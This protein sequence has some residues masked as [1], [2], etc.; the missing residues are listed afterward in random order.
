MMRA[1]LRF[2]RASRNTLDRGALAAATLGGDRAIDRPAGKGTADAARDRTERAM[3]E[4]RIAD[5]RTADATRHQAR[6]PARIA[7]A[8]RIAIAA[9]MRIAV[10]MPLG[11][12]LADRQRDAG[13][14]DE[15]SGGERE[16][17]MAH[18]IF[19][20]RVERCLPNER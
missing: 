14:Q 9:L 6:R 8:V 18:D 17:H 13:R 7:A 11:L 12:G 4:Q 2:R 10:V 1:G 5:E 15:R 16:Q 3:A 19:P 20:F